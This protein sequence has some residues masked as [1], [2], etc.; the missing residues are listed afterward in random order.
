MVPA[1]NAQP[2]VYPVGVGRTRSAGEASTSSATDPQAVQT[3]FSTK[4][5][6]TPAQWMMMT[7]ADRRA[8]VAPA[9]AGSDN[10]VDTML[11]ITEAYAVA[12]LDAQRALGI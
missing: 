5:G 10:P 1:G 6:K 3:L 12:Y 4:L 2:A 9:V 11:T 7:R 8:A